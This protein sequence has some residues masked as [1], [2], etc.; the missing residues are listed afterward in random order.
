MNPIF[1]TTLQQQC[2][3]FVVIPLLLLALILVILSG[4]ENA[5]SASSN[6]ESSPHP[7]E[8]E[9]DHEHSHG[10]AYKP[11]NFKKAVHEIDHRLEHMR[12]DIEHDHLDHVAD[13]LPKLKEFINWLPELAGDTDMQE[14]EWNE[15]K[16]ISQEMLV[17]CESV[18]LELSAGNLDPKYLLELE[19][20]MKLQLELIPLTL[21]QPAGVPVPRP[22]TSV[23]KRTLIHFYT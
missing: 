14:Q 16:S 22:R 11:K 12:E 2:R 5:N 19:S 13:E 20:K 23:V 1:L 15:V 10:P 6:G 8:D 7:K 3:G 21:E 17:I 4:C 9:H 18:A